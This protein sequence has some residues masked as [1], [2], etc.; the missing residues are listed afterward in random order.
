MKQLANLRR[1][2]RWA[3]PAGTMA[4]VG[5]VLAGSMISV[6]QAAPALPS[7][8]PAQLLTAVAGKTSPP[9]LSG[10]V[11]ETASLGLPALPSVV[12]TISL[13]SLL[14]GSHTINVWYSDPAHYRIAIPQSMSESDLVRNGS[15]VWLWGSSANLVTHMALPA[16]GK[17]SSV[18]SMPLT[19]Q[20][21]AS[22]VLAKAGPTTTVSVDNNVTVAG[23]AA[24]Q[25]VLAPKS[26]SSLIGQVRIAIDGQH[27]VPLRVQVFAKGA[28]SPAFQIGF[29]SVSF[30]KPAAANFA[31]RPPV[32]ATVMQ[33]NAGSGGKAAGTVPGSDITSG[34]SVIG[35]GWLAV[36][37]L[38]QSSLSSLT[39]T[40]SSTRS[41]DSALG[42]FSHSSASA[43]PAS[44]GSASGGSGAAGL[45][46][47]TDVIFNALLQS[48]R[49]VSGSWGSGRLLQTSLVSMLITSNGRV[50][51]GAVTPSVLYQAAA[52]PQAA[53]TPLARQHAAVPATSK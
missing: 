14:A 35:K 5:G 30:G 42:P 34:S 12:G 10:T 15:N 1:W 4:V 41:A 25:L 53:H 19:P 26:S 20:Q 45:G 52:A 24:Y 11:V 7:R 49:H 3:V 8:T 44:G 50:L 21:A 16:D 32:G 38:P 48:A 51:I 22:Q 43:A 33:G 23:E 27:N 37:D 39:G 9:P 46:I 18:P 2:S 28:K 31:F 6:A 40:A 29:T 13:P 47:G 36:A 17:A